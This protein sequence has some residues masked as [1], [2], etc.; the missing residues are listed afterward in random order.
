MKGT[1]EVSSEL[2]KGTQF[3]I[4]VPLSKSDQLK[5]AVNAPKTELKSQKKYNILLAE[6]NLVNQ[7]ITIINLQNLGFKVDLAEDGNETWKQ[8]QKNKYDIILMDI[9]MPGLDGIE[10]THMI[11]NYE[12]THPEKARTRIIA[13][14]ANILGQDAEYCLAE[15]MDAY[16]PKPF[17]IEDII[18]KLDPEEPQ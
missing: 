14:T 3:T 16:I 12:I 10:V 5:P 4:I 2:E 7:K 9:Q 6:D 17:K 13:I 18:A 15:G 8:Y 1:I 11:R